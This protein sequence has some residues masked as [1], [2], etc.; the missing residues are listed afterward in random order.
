MNAKV[1]HQCLRRITAGDYDGSDVHFV[2]K[3]M[4]N[5]REGTSHQRRV[6]RGFVA[7]PQ[8]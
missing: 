1:G 4:G 3:L 6:R 7:L 2:Y 5:R 8:R